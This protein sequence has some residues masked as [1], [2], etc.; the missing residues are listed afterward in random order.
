MSRSFAW[1]I[2]AFLF[3]VATVYAQPAPFQPGEELAPDVGPEVYRASATETNGEVTVQV[4]WRSPRIGRAVKGP[5]DRGWVNVWEKVKPLTL[6]KTISAYRKNG[7]IMSNEAVLKALSKEQAVVCF[8]LPEGAEEKP[9]P[10]LLEPFRDDAV[11]LV[12][13]G[14][15][16]RP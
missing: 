8:V 6:G 15:A 5:P 4:I 14:S 2:L 10:I 12:F 16:T 1:S 13:H 3:S 7:Q 9:A 11:I